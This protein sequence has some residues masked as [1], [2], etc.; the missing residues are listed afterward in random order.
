MPKSQTSSNLYKLNQRG[1]RVENQDLD[2]ILKIQALQTSSELKVTSSIS[3][4]HEYVQKDAHIVK[5][6]AFVR[7]KLIQSKYKQIL[8]AV[9]TVQRLY[10]KLR[11]DRQVKH[12]ALSL[13]SAIK[14]LATIKSALLKSRKGTQK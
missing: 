11:H 13:R 5:L 8:R 10:R 4:T 9:N 12:R 7:M 14:L 1:E 2:T 6:Q 3:K